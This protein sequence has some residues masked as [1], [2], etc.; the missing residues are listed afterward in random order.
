M[1]Q[2]VEEDGGGQRQRQRHAGAPDQ[3]AGRP[4]KRGQTIAKRAGQGRGQHQEQ[5]Q[6]AGMEMNVD[7]ERASETHASLVDHATDQARK[8]GVTEHDDRLSGAGRGVS[9]GSA[10]ARGT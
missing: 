5:E 2:F 9:T 4:R 8:H 1:G 6:A 7:A 10:G 3:R